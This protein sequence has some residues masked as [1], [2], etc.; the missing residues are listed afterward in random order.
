MRTRAV[1]R[2]ARTAPAAPPGTPPA[3]SRAPD[4]GALEREIDLVRQPGLDVLA[5]PGEHDL[6]VPRARHD[7]GDGG[8]RLQAA[9]GRL[10]ARAR[11]P[12]RRG[13]GRLLRGAG[14][15]GRRA[16]VAGARVASSG[17]CAGGWE[18]PGAVWPPVPDSGP[19]TIATPAGRSDCPL[20]C[21]DAA[22]GLV[23]E[24][25]LSSWS[26]WLITCISMGAL[27]PRRVHRGALGCRAE[28]DLGVAD[29][30]AVRG[31]GRP[32][33]LFAGR[34]SGRPV[35]RRSRRGR[36]CRRRPRSGARPEDGG[37]RQRLGRITGGSSFLPGRARRGRAATRAPVRWM[38][39]SAGAA[40]GVTRCEA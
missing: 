33:A 32:A 1:T 4:A 37:G 3:A 30:D 29:R 14:R 9:G 15:L 17:G 25:S 40:T 7:P 18:A 28:D 31:H 20:I 26:D 34:R 6:G 39:G 10:A 2:P 38:R 27:P 8:R 13:V 24:T 36:R 16:G 5:Q 11:R 35:R 23:A 12:G 21:T 19:T 22:T